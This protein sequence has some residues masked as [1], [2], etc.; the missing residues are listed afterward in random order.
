M[1]KLRNKGW[2][3]YERMLDICPNSS[4]RGENTFSPS[5]FGP[6]PPPPGKPV[7][8]DDEASLLGDDTATSFVITGDEITPSNAGSSTL[9]STPPAEKRKLDDGDG[10]IS[11][12]SARSAPPTS[13]SISV[14][15]SSAAAESEQPKKKKRSNKAS[16]AAPSSRQASN[17]TSEKMT[18][19]LLVHE[20]QGSLNQLT[21]A[22]TTGLTLDPAAE[23][24]RKATAILQQNDDGLT[25]EDSVILLTVFTKDPATV[26]TYNTLYKA[27]LRKPWVEKIINAEKRAELMA[28]RREEQ[29]DRE[30]ML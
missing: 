20:M 16:S 10:A 24:V 2:P 30:M 7:P 5:T 21:S 27:H 9:I 15:S 1:K 25:D 19:F 29:E 14:H 17:K 4:A 6:H 22:V 18:P 28:R 12:T 8:L 26:N 3:P 13:S 11:L 23:T